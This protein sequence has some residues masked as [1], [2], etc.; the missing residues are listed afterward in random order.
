MHITG[1]GLVVLWLLS[2]LGSQAVLRISSIVPDTTST[3]Q[4]LPYLNVS[5]W[6]NLPGDGSD[7]QL[8]LIAPNT[9]LNAALISPIASKNAVQDLWGHVKVPLLSRMPSNSTDPDG[10]HQV[11]TSNVDD[12][13][14]LVGIPVGYLPGSSNQSTTLALQSWYWNLECDSWKSGDPFGLGAPAPFSFN[15]NSTE[16]GRSTNYDWPAVTVY[17]DD[18]PVGNRA[19]NA[20]NVSSTTEDSIIHCPELGARTLGFLLPQQF[21][22]PYYTTCQI[23]TEYVETEV[24][25]SGITCTPKRIRQS[26]A[27]HL[28]NNWTA[29]DVWS[30][31]SN[32]G[33]TVPSLFFNSFANS[34][35][36]RQ[37][38]SGGSNA[39]AGYITNPSDPFSGNSRDSINEPSLQNVTDSLITA[40]LT[41][42]LN[43]YWITSIG[44]Q[45]ITGTDATLDN[46]NQLNL[47]FLSP[48]MNGA[49]N[50]TGTTPA[51]IDT[52]RHKLHCSI[53]WLVAF[54]IVTLIALVSA[55][56]GL[57][58]VSM[59][60]GP[61][62]AMNISTILRDNQYSRAVQGGSYLDDSERSRLL[63][64]LTVRIGD[65]APG[66]SVGH[67]AVSTVDAAGRAIVVGQLTKERLYD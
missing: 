59:S 49:T 51:T 19:T 28:L 1:T 22:D 15:R 25:C 10:W 6:N 44:S 52:P 29:L 42:V 40:R 36:G 21:S 58:L 53:E 62:L 31:T 45:L 63:H 55:I 65:V 4:T 33:Y 3:N 18:N 60:Q 50:M 23:T 46:A 7:G 56:L 9:L 34:I 12:F 13:S 37:G 20:C 8:F 48:S 26:Q 54:T 39:L 61:R 16:G 2:P 35:A 64:D 17:Y 24:S 30:G 66:E 38:G 41:Q 11:S 14:S 5:N 47:Q 27:F 67:I 43:T 57:V 32:P